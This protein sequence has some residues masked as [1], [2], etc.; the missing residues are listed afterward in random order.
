MKNLKKTQEKKESR[1]KDWSRPGRDRQNFDLVARKHGSEFRSRLFPFG[2]EVRYRRPIPYRS[3]LKFD[4]RG[5]AGML[6][7]RRSLEPTLL[8]YQNLFGSLNIY[9]LIQPI[10]H[11]TH[12]ITVIACVNPKYDVD[13]G[14]EKDLFT[15][16][17]NQIK[18]GFELRPL[19]RLRSCEPRSVESK[20]RK[21]CTKKLYGASS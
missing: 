4:V 15:Y 21:R 16:H 2:C 1:P 9:L 5:Y 19:F 17:K 3:G 7:G 10:R 14:Y 20:S 12:H 8:E 11:V 6:L 18:H 13:N